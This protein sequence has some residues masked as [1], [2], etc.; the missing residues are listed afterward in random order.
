MSRVIYDGVPVPDEPKASVSAAEFLAQAKAQV[1]EREQA[2]TVAG[3]IA[4]EE[5][6]PK[7]SRLFTALVIGIIVIAITNLYWPIRSIHKDYRKHV[8]LEQAEVKYQKRI[9]SIRAHESHMLGYYNSWVA[10]AKA[11]G[12]RQLVGELLHEVSQRITES[13]NEIK[14]EEKAMDKLRREMLK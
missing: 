14:A 13:D 12:D 8:A 2:I 6:A 9:Q 4:Y 1:A 10:N 11:A 5:K 7:R 3:Y